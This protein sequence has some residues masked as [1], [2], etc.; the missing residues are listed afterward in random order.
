MSFAQAFPSLYK[1]PTAAPKHS[2]LPGTGQ[3]LMCRGP[4]Y[5][6]FTKK[7]KSDMV[8]GFVQIEMC[9]ISAM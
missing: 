1:P 4:N 3:P 5:L 6:D 9:P 8:N 7:Q 2:R